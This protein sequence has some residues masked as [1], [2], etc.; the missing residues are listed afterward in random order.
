MTTGWIP[1]FDQSFQRVPVTR[2]REMYAAGYRVMAGYAGGGT[3]NKWLTPAE[4][5][6]WRALGPDTAVAALFEVFG[7]EPISN[8]TLGDD[9]ARAARA[10]WRALGYPDACAI[11]PAVDENVT[12][13]QARAQLTTYFAHWTAADTC[14]PIAYVEMDAGAVLAAAGVT[15]GTFTPAAFSWD[16]SGHLVTPA[17]APAHVM[18][19]QEHNGQSLAGG[20]VDIGHIRLTAPVWWTT[21]HAPDGGDM[22]L[23][24]ADA[25]TI[26]TAD[27]LP[28]FPWAADAKTN[29]T[30][31]LETAVLVAGNQAHAAYQ[32]LGTVLDLLGQ[33]AKVEQAMALALAG[34]PA[35]VQVTAA[36]LQAALVG[37]LKQLATP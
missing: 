29:P 19:T 16:A 13:T 37:A 8:P 20:N 5:K 4:I 34:M 12:V 1:V 11:S 9:H 18:W 22:P 15:A 3:S 17:N 31:S 25:K 6:A 21:T 23:T 30:I 14:K 7:T 26:V 24:V 36:E 10:A 27:V 28:N 2:L 35:D 33:S 32:A